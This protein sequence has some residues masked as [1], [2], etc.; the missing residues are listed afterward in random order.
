MHGGI[1]AACSAD[2]EQYLRAGTSTHWT[3][4]GTKARTCEGQCKVRL[5]GV[6]CAAW[7]KKSRNR[8]VFLPTPALGRSPRS[9]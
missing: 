7:S 6:M 2:A 5:W 8:G 9:L 4:M 1:A 3:V